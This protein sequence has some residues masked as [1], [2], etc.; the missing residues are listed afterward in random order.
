MPWVAVR[1]GVTHSSMVQGLAPIQAK[2]VRDHPVHQ[3]RLY[4]LFVLLLPRQRQVH[5]HVVY[6][7]GVLYT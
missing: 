4:M 6:S 7:C 1:L 2:A 5:P 3:E